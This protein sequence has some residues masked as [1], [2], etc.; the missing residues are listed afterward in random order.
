[1]APRP[2]SLDHIP[3]EHHL[4]IGLVSNAWS[5]LEGAAE[6]IIWRLLRCNDDAGV[7]LTTHIGIR[8]RLDI[9][10]SLVKLE[11]PSSKAAKAFPSLTRRILGK[12]IYGKRNEIVHSRT[13]HLDT[14]IRPTYKARGV[15]KKELKL[16]GIGE[17]EKTAKAILIE[18]DKLLIFLA[19]IID[20]VTQKDGEHPP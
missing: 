13:L 14:T 6:R 12:E 1:M 4:G 16:A 17:Y 18:T 15:L 3:P 19:E 8:Q 5:H 9:V 20:L 11:F 10:S 7:A 2:L